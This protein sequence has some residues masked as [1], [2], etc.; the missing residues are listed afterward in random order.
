MS[1]TFLHSWRL[2]PISNVTIQW[3][4]GKSLRQSL[5]KCRLTE[6][7][8]AHFYMHIRAQT[9][10][11]R[12]LTNLAIWYWD[13]P[14][15]SWT[16]W[17]MPPSLWRCKSRLDPWLLLHTENSTVT[18]SKQVKRAVVIIP[19]LKKTAVMTEQVL[20][21]KCL[22]DTSSDSFSFLLD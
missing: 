9:V 7:V 19:I 4:V 5:Q 21:N 3:T 17:D 8:L 18:L 22:R 10:C 1:V 16:S 15:R 2:P 11:G 14:K 12:T 13:N 20:M 6:S